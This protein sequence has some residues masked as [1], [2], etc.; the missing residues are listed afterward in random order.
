[1][2][3]ERVVTS[4]FLLLSLIL[5]V[6]TD[7][8]TGQRVLI[9]GNSYI[10]RNGLTVMVQSILGDT[11][12]VVQYARPS[13]GLYQHWQGVQKNSASELALLFDQE[14]DWIVMQDSSLNPVQLL[15]A[16]WNIVTSFVIQRIVE[17]TSSKNYALFQTWGR[18][19]GWKQ[20]SFLTMSHQ[21]YER[22][23][24]AAYYVEENSDDGKVYVAPV[25]RAFESVYNGS[26]VPFASLYH[27]DGSHPSSRGTYLAACCIAGTIMSPTSQD[28]SQNDFV[29]KRMNATTAATLR[30]VA[31]RI[32]IQEGTFA[33]TPSPC[34]QVG[35]SCG[36]E[37]S[38]CEA[39]T[40]IQ[41]TCLARK[42]APSTSKEDSKLFGEDNQRGYLTRKLKG[43]W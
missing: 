29:P 30:E 32:L 12:Q 26:D 35:M 14:W 33:A 28:L 13:K 8:T 9:I 7:D 40:C 16:T 21:V 3:Q 10:R 38:C 43:M 17:S 15:E 5:L 1:M 31:T 4:S 18:R 23:Q 19:D 11:A 37:Q 39:S 22:Y 20:F 34:T 36:V 24:S 41:R 2:L 42:K 27:L 6:M 25:G